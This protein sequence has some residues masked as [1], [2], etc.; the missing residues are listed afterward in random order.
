MGTHKKMKNL[1]NKKKLRQ[2]IL[3]QYYTKTQIIAA[4]AQK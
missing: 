4:K 1:S 3:D 2:Q